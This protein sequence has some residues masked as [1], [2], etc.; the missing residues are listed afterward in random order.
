MA[1]LDQADAKH[2]YVI[3]PI[4]LQRQLKVDKLKIEKLKMDLRGTREEKMES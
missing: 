2:G 1:A 4:E 3:I